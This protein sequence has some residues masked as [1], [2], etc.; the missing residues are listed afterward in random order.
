MPDEQDLSPTSAGV[1]ETLRKIRARTPARILVG[2]AGA[3]HRR[4]TQLD[5]RE[6]HAA[7][8]DAVRGELSLAAI[9]DGAF[10]QGGNLCE[11]STR[12]Q[13]KNEYL[14]RPDLGRRFD[15]QSCL[16]LQRHCSREADFLIAI[17][18]GLSVSAV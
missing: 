10:V 15:D 5:L 7:A 9:F 12:A 16:T 3:S 1:S 17:G 2:R 6:A 4:S 8:R 14:L 13:N 18:D 11:L